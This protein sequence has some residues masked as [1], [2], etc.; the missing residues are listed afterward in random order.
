MIEKIILRQLTQDSKLKRQRHIEENGQQYEVGQPTES[1][2]EQQEVAGS[3]D[4][5]PEQHKLLSGICTLRN[6]LWWKMF[7]NHFLGES[8]LL[9]Y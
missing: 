5:L 1:V 8:Q 9:K 3:Q 2:C 7:M 4:E 6:R